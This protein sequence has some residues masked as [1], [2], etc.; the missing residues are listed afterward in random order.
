MARKRS[1][2]ASS[3]L[4]AALWSCQP[5]RYLEATWV[6]DIEVTVD[7][8]KT[9]D[10]AIT[11][12]LKMRPNTNVF[13]TFPYAWLYAQA[14]PNRAT[15]TANWLRR[16]GEK[17]TLWDSTLAQKDLDQL[18]LKMKQDGYFQA[19]AS[20]QL[21]EHSKGSVLTYA[22]ERG[23]GTRVSQLYFKSMGPYIDPFLEELQTASLLKSNDALLRMETLEGERKRIADYL[24]NHGFYTFGPEAVH[25]DV[26]TLGHPLSAIVTVRLDNWIRSSE[27]GT[28]EEPHRIWIVR[29]ARGQWPESM[30]LK[31]NG[32]QRLPWIP[33]HQPFQADLVRESA[34]GLRGIPAIQSGRW[35]F[36][37]VQDSLNAVL[38]LVP[39]QRVGLTWKGESTALSGIYGVQSSLEVY[40]HNPFG[41]LEHVNITLSGGIGAQLADTSNLFNTYFLDLESGIQWPGLWGWRNHQLPGSNTRLNLSFGRQYRREFDR[42]ALGAA[43]H[44]N[45]RSTRGYQWDVSPLDMTY[46]DLRQIDS[47]FYQALSVKS[48]FQDIFLLG[49]RIRVIHPSIRSGNWERRTE[50]SFESSGLL[51]DATERLLNPNGE[52]VRTIAG[53]PYAHYLRAKVDLRW[54]HRGSKDRDWAF[55]LVAGE[56]HTLRNTPGLPPFERAF[57]AGGSN[58][59]RGWLNFRLGPGALPLAVF[60]STGYLGSGTRKLLFQLE[61]R[62]PIV[63]DLSAAVFSDAGNTWLLKRNLAEP[64]NSLLADP[65]IQQRIEFTPARLFSQTAWDV[66]IGLRYDLEFFILRVDWGLQVYDPRRL[67]NQPWWKGSEWTQRS[68]LNFGL[69]MP[70]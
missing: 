17:P 69:G 39:A 42:L 46:I 57:F 22:I 67:G 3:L 30:V 70:F 54:L 56:L 10:E 68:T 47:S 8:R 53:I 55:R 28:V 19:T 51:T 5:Q 63:G 52:A 29:E 13:G 41:G 21:R 31:P 25:F 32:I 61:Y 59:L 37:P 50:W 14:G 49:P 1:L 12:V 24:Q 58:D 7:Q 4:L 2:L 35:Q 20:Y 62:F 40:D 9:D 44:Y 27:Y 64:A 34:A 15:K 26:D 33:I 43:L 38:T 66:G 48:G 6:R 60:D 18:I 65:D 36:K 16:I 23:Q 45:F 11:E